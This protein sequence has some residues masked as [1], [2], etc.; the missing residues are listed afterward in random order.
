MSAK[1]LWGVLLA[2][3]FGLVP[4]GAWA[5]PSVGFDIT[6]TDIRVGETFTVD[7]VVDGVDLLDEVIAFGFEV[8]FDSAWSQAASPVIG[9]AFDFDDSALFPN[10]DVAASV[11]FLNM[12]PSG[13]GILLATLSFVSGAAGVFD[14]GTVSDLLDLNEGLLTFLDTYDLTHSEEVTVNTAVNGV[15]EPATLALLGGGIAGIGYRR[16]R[17]I[18]T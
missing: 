16:W 6:D 1:R 14:L 17:K 5:I 11:D 9:P 15:P 8:D 4:V 10:T 3:L 7:V 12:G 13:D 18:K 2:G